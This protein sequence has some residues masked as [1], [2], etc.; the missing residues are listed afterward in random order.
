VR[1]KALMAYITGWAD[2]SV[3]RGG[4]FA[5]VRFSDVLDLPANVEGEIPET[6]TKSLRGHTIHDFF[7]RWVDIPAARLG[8]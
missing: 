7:A 6:A 1:S 2:Y 3:R 4:S 5:T 8:C